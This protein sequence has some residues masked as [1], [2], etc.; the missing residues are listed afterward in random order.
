VQKAKN[1]INIEKYIPKF[2]ASLMKLN[3]DNIGDIVKNI[4]GIYKDKYITVNG[5][6]YRLF[7]KNKKK[8]VLI[9]NSHLYI[10]R[11]QIAIY[12]GEKELVVYSPEDIEKRD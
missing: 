6:K 1:S 8:G 5:N 10:K 2:K 4:K 11:A 12:K 3:S 9:K 7:V